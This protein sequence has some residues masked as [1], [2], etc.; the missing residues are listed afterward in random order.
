MFFI[1]NQKYMINELPLPEQIFRT[2]LT[3]KRILE[4]H[5]TLLSEC[6]NE[7]ATSYISKENLNRITPISIH[8]INR[9]SKQLK[10]RPM[11]SYDDVVISASENLLHTVVAAYQESRALYFIDPLLIESLKTAKFP[12]S[13]PVTAF[14][15]LPRKSFCIKIESDWYSIVFDVINGNDLMIVVYKLLPYTNKSF[16]LKHCFITLID[17]NQ[18][19]SLQSALNVV[20]SLKHDT[21]NAI[22]NKDYSTV[23][24]EEYMH[25]VPKVKMNLKDFHD[26]SFIDDS[27]RASLLF[28]L[29]LYIAND[30]DTVRHVGHVLRPMPKKQIRK[31]RSE[32]LDTQELTQQPDILEVGLKFGAAIKRY[33]SVEET[34]HSDSG[35]GSSKKPHIRSAHSHLYWRNDKESI[36]ENGKPLK[37]PIVRFLAPMAIKGGT[38]INDV[39]IVQ[40]VQ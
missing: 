33:A 25:Y 15:A 19:L 35:T 24:K 12:Q 10:C 23:T 26:N 28:N 38:T 27:E 37:I 36:D 30:E 11:N 13:T 34:T 7:R 18:P 5:K 9:I 31:A 22:E 2:F 8:T 16:L 4:N 1:I 39:A 40:Q 20:R 21:V 3:D 6:S 32:G 14:L 17:R 29:L